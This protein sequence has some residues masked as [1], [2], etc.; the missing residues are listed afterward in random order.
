MSLLVPFIITIITFKY[1]FLCLPRVLVA[2][3]R[4]FM[5]HVGSLAV[6]YESLVCSLW[7]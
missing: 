3:R 1:V 5:R 7:A 2:A 4:V 6:V